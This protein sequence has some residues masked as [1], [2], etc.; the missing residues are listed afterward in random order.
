MRI[1]LVWTASSC[2]AKDPPPSSVALHRTP[3]SIQVVVSPC[4]IISRHAVLGNDAS[5]FH[6]GPQIM[7]GNSCLGFRV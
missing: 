7:Q 1:H 2:H 3:K 6:R 4:L 5:L